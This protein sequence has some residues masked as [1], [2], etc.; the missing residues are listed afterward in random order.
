M[1][2]GW[3]WLFCVFGFG[4]VCFFLIEGGYD[5]FF[6]II[7]PLLSLAGTSGG[8]LSNLS[9]QAQPPTARS[10]G[11]RLDGYGVP[12]RV[13][14][15]QPPLTTSAS[16]QSLSQWAFPPWCSEGAPCISAC[17]PCLCSCHWTSLKRGWLCPPCTLSFQI[18]LLI[19]KLSLSLP[20]SGLSS[21]RS[22]S[23]LIGEL[24]W[25]LNNLS[26]HLMGSFQYVHVSLVLGSPELDSALQVWLDQCWVKE[27]DHIPSSGISSLPFSAIYFIFLFLKKYDAK[28]LLYLIPHLGEQNRTLSSSEVTNK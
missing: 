17:F 25:S 3:V 21:P 15:P 28:V 19:G 11:P 26:G 5:W 14:A 18:L 16:V 12:S 23:L 7:T 6:N 8:H 2:W 27:K 22:L 1:F 13:E 4:F 10:L 20:F 24:F 9:V